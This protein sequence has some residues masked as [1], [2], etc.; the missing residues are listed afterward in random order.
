[1]LVATVSRDDGGSTLAETI[2]AMV[3][4]GLLITGTLRLNAVAAEALLNRETSENMAEIA[5]DYLNETRLGDCSDWR[6]SNGIGGDNDHYCYAPLS[7]HYDDPTNPPAMT[8]VDCSDPMHKGVEFVLARH[9][10][11]IRFEMTVTVFDCYDI[12]GGSEMPVR[13]VRVSGNGKELE[14][15][16]V[17]V[18]SP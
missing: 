9:L 17:G 3:L 14:R 13:V 7:T 2:V 6:I 11:D 16:S 5:G 1:M 12:V 8:E 15:A 10:P 18:A 4:L